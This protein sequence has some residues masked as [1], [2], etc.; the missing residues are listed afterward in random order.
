[1]C[2]AIST[3]SESLLHA[4]YNRILGTPQGQP[5][6]GRRATAT[7]DRNQLA[8]SGP[9]CNDVTVRSASHMHPIRP[10]PCPS[11]ALRA[12]AALA[13][14]GGLNL[15]AA[16]N[17]AERAA[18][19]RAV[20]V[21][22]GDAPCR[23]DSE[24]LTIALPDQA[25]GGTQAWLAYS[26]RSTD[27]AALRQALQRQAAAA[28]P[29]AASTCGIVADPGAVCLPAPT[30]ADAQARGCRLRPRGAGN[31]THWQPQGGYAPAHCA[32]KTVVSR[33]RPSWQLAHAPGHRV[34]RDSN[35]GGLAPGPNLVCGGK[36]CK[37]LP[38]GH[39]PQPSPSTGR[40]QWVRCS[41]R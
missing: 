9:E 26:T 2:G 18:A 22:V 6:A 7:R 4:L 10:C 21:L 11:L 14:L 13:L 39:L 16:A 25:C 20:A 40:S 24:C 41:P 34:G 8:G 15:H 27:S 28:T 23:Q 35:L 30:A 36:A 5:V 33:C 3:G 37:V 32:V 17:P 1:M 31:S 38:I 12:C 19:Q 29:G